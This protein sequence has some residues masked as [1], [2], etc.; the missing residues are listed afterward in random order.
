METMVRKRTGVRGERH[1]NHRLTENQV[2]EIYSRAWSGEKQIALAVEFSV[3]QQVISKI[4]V[5]GR[6]G[7]LEKGDELN[8]TS[9]I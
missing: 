5:G 2:R 8:H 3:S 1:G 4:K 6:W 9:R 7:W